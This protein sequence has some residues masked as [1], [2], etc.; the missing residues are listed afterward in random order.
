MRKKTHDEFVKEVKELVGDEY[1]VLSEYIHAKNP[2]WMKHNE[3]GSVYE[4]RPSN[5]LSGKR[6]PRCFDKRRKDIRF[7]GQNEFEKEFYEKYKGKFELASEYN[8]ARTHIKIKC[9]KCGEQFEVTPDQLLR[10]N[11]TCQGC[12]G[13]VSNTTTYKRKVFKQVGDEY[14]VLGEYVKYTVHIQMKHNV[15]GHEFP[16][17]PD[18]FLRGTRCPN[19]HPLRLKTQEEFEEKVVEL[20]GDEYSVLEEYKGSK[21]KILMRHNVCGYEWRTEPSGFVHNGRRCPQ[22]SNKVVT[23]NNSLQAKYPY[24]SEEWHTTLNGDKTPNDF[25]PGSD[26]KVWWK[27]RDCGHEWENRIRSRS[28]EKHQCPSC[29]KR[30][31]ESKGER[32]VKECLKKL[33]IKFKSPHGYPDCKDKTTLLYDVA[34]LSNNNEI[35]C[36]I[37]FDGEQH[38]YPVDYFGGEEGFKGAI[39]RDHIKNK[40][41]EENNIILIRIPYWLRDHVDEVLTYW[42]QYYG[43]ISSPDY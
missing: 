3:C 37:E 38:F 30:K 22:C 18:S 2:V 8:G 35:L 33:G 10:Y 13:G 20:V 28:V 1:E 39:K 9:L 23:D 26:V 25:T 12:R 29:S 4:V 32:Y 16:V 6:C 40:Y 36:L 42:L 17:R 24:L 5:F 7:K 43:I 14:T 41:C 31:G 19:C 34:V 21:Q 15:C 11:Q 27:C